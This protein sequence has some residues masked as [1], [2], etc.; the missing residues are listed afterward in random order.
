[1]ASSKA[2]RPL[3][4]AESKWPCKSSTL[5]VKGLRSSACSLKPTRKNSSCGLA[6]FLNSQGA[7]LALVNDLGGG[8]AVYVVGDEGLGEGRHRQA[9]AGEPTEQHKDEW[10]P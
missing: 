7:C 9:Q 8:G 2:V 1:M 6:V 3:A 5:L 4:E 10:N